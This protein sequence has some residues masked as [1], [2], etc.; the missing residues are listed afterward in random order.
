MM[1]AAR[2]RI[3]DLVVSCKACATTYLNQILFLYVVL[4]T[5]I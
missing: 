4:H 2:Y 1:R 5:L 3:K